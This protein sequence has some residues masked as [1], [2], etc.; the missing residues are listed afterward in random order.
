MSSLSSRAGREEVSA[1]ELLLRNARQG[2]ADALGQLLKTYQNYLTI[3]ATTQL[4]SKLRRRMNPSDLVQETLL[5]AHRDFQKFR[6]CSEREFL[7]WLRQVLI[8]C[9]H[10][11]IEMHL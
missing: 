7:G 5:A 6:G 1:I 2:Q 8:H 9:L 10:H 11:A 3:L 4:D